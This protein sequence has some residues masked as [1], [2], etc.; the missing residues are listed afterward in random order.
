MEIVIETIDGTHHVISILDIQQYETIDE[1][2]GITY[3]I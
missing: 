2:K 3:E 1:K